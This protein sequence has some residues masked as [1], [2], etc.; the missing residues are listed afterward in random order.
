MNAITAIKA[1]EFK[2]GEKTMK[3]E[4]TVSAFIFLVLWTTGTNI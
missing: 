3:A 4:K 2:R 1:S